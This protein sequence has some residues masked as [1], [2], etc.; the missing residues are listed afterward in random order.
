ME[1][2][3]QLSDPL[4]NPAANE[5][6]TQSYPLQLTIHHRLVND[7]PNVQHMAAFIMIFLR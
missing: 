2:I 6:A 1:L 5:L 4:H 7:Q 3:V